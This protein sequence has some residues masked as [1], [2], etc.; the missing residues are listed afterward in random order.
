MARCLF[1]I[2]GVIA[3]LILAQPADAATPAVGSVSF[4][5]SGAPAAQADFLT[6]LAQLHNFQYA[7]AAAA[8]Q[9]AQEIDPDFA[10]AYWGE[11]MTY[12]HG[13]WMQQDRSAGRAALAKLGP[14]PEARSAK[15][16]TP[17]EKAYLAAVEVLYGDG[18][19]YDRDR[20]YALA[21]ERVHATI[22]RTSM[23][24]ASTRS[25]CSALHMPAATCPR[26]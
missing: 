11:A 21:M 5:N 17:R 18:D 9:R 25:L 4:A 20:R 6:G 8:F 10:V 13:V 2:V 7:Q 16:P 19:K 24:P 14:T 22:R 12:N 15:A 23:Q 1:S 3:S 26:T